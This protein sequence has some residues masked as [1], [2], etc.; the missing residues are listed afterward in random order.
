MWIF[1]ELYRQVIHRIPRKWRITF[2]ATLAVLIVVGLIWHSSIQTKKAEVK[3]WQE[4]H[5]MIEG[6]DF[7][8]YDDVRYKDGW[9]QV[10]W[11]RLPKTAY[12]GFTQRW[13]MD[14]IGRDFVEIQ[15]WYYPKGVAEP[16]FE[17]GG[18]SV[19]ALEPFWGDQV[20]V[21]IL[22]PGIYEVKVVYTYDK[23]C[24]EELGVE[25][26]EPDQRIV[27]EVTHKIMVTD[28]NI[29]ITSSPTIK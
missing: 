7:H 2:T 19:K 23:E 24:W 28:E 16:Y 17:L 14:K 11:V 13:Y 5:A 15:N 18:D 27:F 1:N 6:K 26:F 20:H 10:H 4:Y 3:A 12:C 21:G 8:F 22:R 25:G 9:I 29:T